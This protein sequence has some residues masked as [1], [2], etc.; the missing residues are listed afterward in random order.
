MRQSDPI[1]TD[2]IVICTGV[3]SEIAAGACDAQP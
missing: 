2:E 1:V 3:R